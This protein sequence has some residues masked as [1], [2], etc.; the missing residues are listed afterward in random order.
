MR[1]PVPARESEPQHRDNGPKLGFGP[2]RTRSLPDA[3]AKVLEEYL[4][5]P[6]PAPPAAPDS[7]VAAP[8]AA[9][10]TY[11]TVHAHSSAALSGTG[12]ANGHTN[13][14][15]V[16]TGPRIT[17]DLCPDCGTAL[18]YEEGCSKCM[19]CGYARC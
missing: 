1:Q 6:R 9:A 11:G 2:E 17:G 7:P 19:G 3:L 12:D 16:L 15:I 13:G 10:P 14:H 18:V 4:D 5:R 8:K